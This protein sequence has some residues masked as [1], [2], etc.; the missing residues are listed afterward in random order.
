MDMSSYLDRAL[1]RIFAV[2]LRESDAKH[3]TQ[4]NPSPDMYAN[5]VIHLQGLAEVTLR[6]QSH[7][8]NQAR[9][10]RRLMLRLVACLARQELVSENAPLALTKDSLD[11]MMMARLLDPPEQYPQWP[12]DYL[13]GCYGRVSQEIR[14]LTTLK[15]KEAA[16]A[17]QLDLQYCKQLITRNA[18]LLLTMALFPQVTHTHHAL[19]CK[20]MVLCPPVPQSCHAQTTYCILSAVHD[21][22]THALP[23]GSTTLMQPQRT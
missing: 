18:G 13:I 19:F 14:A 12:L 7:A 2:S 6:L 11:R 1:S 17:T 16:D 15:N 3:A 23:N 20:A 21:L 22:A 8:L 5:P 9:L 10:L 4:P